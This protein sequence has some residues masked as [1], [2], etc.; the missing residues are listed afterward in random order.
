MFEFST[1][2]LDR[3]HT[4][5]VDLIMIMTEAIKGYDF[6]ILS[7]FRDAQE[8]NE[9]VKLGYSQLKWPKSKHNQQ[10]SEGIDIAPYPIDWDDLNRFYYLAGRIDAI[11]DILLENQIIHHTIV[12]GGDWSKFK[13]Y[14]HFELGA[15]LT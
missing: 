14:G 11:A 4:C 3:L 10:P 9:K 8:Q 7:G 5:H 13:D 2:S 15:Y 1:K 6:S 12:W